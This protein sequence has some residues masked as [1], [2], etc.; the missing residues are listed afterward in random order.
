MALRGVSSSSAEVVIHRVDTNEQWLG[1]YSYAPLLDENGRIT[2]AVVTA[3]DLTERRQEQE[4]LREQESM[5][6]EMSTMAHIGAWEYDPATGKGT[7]TRVAADI[8]GLDPDGPADKALG[9]NAFRGEHRKRAER[10]LARAEATGKP[11]DIELELVSKDGQYRWVRSICHPVT[12]QGKVVKV[13]GTIQD[14]TDRKLIEIDLKES[15]DRY[16]AILETAIDGFF[17]ANSEGRI[18]EVNQ[19]YLNMSGY[20]RSDLIGKNIA[21]IEALET[22]EDIRDRIKHIQE[23]GYDRF[24]TRHIRR[25]GSSWPLE[26]SVTSIP[27]LDNQTFAFVH[28]ISER[29]ENEQKI[30]RYVSMLEESMEGTL[31][32]ISNMVEQRDPYTAGHERRV[33]ILACDIAVAMGWPEE[34]AH[35]LQLIGLVHDIGKI[36]VPAEILSKPGRLTTVEYELVKN[37]V[38]M[39]YEILKDVKFPLPIAEIIYQHHE[40]LDGSGYPR[41]LKGDEILQEARILAV[42][43]VLESMSSHRPYRPALG[44]EVALEELKKNRGSLYDP[45]VIDTVLRMVNE[46]K[47]SLP[48]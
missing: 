8:F 21:D 25:D 7:H 30:A 19:S 12:H 28:D 1:E 45:D 37:H 35:D 27:Q 16:R 13:K 18:I 41:G 17:V 46:D 4:K 29:R 38:V 42:A 32:A 31:T 10:Y 24:E 6:V 34:K 39:G 40:R 23:T 15:E 20:R 47:Y 11:F 43:D 3:R 33:G 26:I 9:I 5:L 2:G 48:E 22:S 44:I 14:I 36:G